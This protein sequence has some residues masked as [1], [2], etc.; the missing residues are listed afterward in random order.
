MENTIEA[1]QQALE[2]M[3]AASGNFYF[4]ATRTNCHAFIEFTGLMNEYIKVCE[5]MTAQGDTSWMTANTHSG[6]PLKMES[7]EL[8]YLSEKLDCIYG[9]TM[10]ATPGFEPKDRLLKRVKE[11][12]ERQTGP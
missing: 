4:A 6:L 8:D 10:E 7:Y 12:H 5:R 2:K 11:A 9:P 1:A 3:R